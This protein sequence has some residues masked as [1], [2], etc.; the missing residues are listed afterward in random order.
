M[1]QK[2]TASQIVFISNPMLTRSLLKQAATQGSR[3]QPCFMCG[4]PV[5]S[6]IST[7]VKLNRTRTYF[8]RVCFQSKSF[9]FQYQTNLTM[10]ERWLTT[11]LQ[12]TP[13][14]TG[15]NWFQ[16]AS[17][18]QSLAMTNGSVQLQQISGGDS[19]RLQGAAVESGM[20]QKVNGRKGLL[21]KH[22]AH[23]T[24]LHPATIHD[25]N[26]QG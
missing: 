2:P 10:S 3:Q 26:L 15:K 4:N 17:T 22:I 13:Q 16:L 14:Q 12:D 20:V 19:S 9:S 8:V 21:N 1:R 25:A 24:H 7:T 5:G 18:R 6:S 11:Y 23:S